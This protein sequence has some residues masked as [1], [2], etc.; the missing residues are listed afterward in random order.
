MCGIYLTNIPYQQQEIKAKIKKIGYRGPDNLGITQIE[1]LTLGHLRLSILDLDQRSNQ[2]F[3]FEQFY[4]TYNGEIYNFQSI[5]EDLIKLGYSFKTTSDTEVLVIGYSVWGKE[6]L[7]KL[8]GMF[9]FAIYDSKKEEIFCARDRLGVK[10][11]F[12]YWKDGNI[13]ICS[14]LSPLMNK[15]LTINQEAISI[16][17]DCG[18]IPS[19]FSIYNEIQ[20]LQPGYCMYI[21]LKE[22]KLYLEK[23]WDL[24]SAKVDESISYETAKDKLHELITDAVK[25][26]MQADVPL[27][28]FLSGGIDSALV[29]AIAAK[30]S[31]Q[32]L[33]TF[34][35][36]FEDPDFDESKVAEQYAGIINSEH[37]TTL[38][39]PKEVLEMLP[40]LINAYDE[41]FADSSA[42]PSLLLNKVTKQHVTVAL[43]GD[44]G[45]ESFIGYKHMLLVEQFKKL[46]VLHYHLRKV[47][48]WIPVNKL[49]NK[50]AEA[51]KGILGCKNENELIIKVFAQF[52]TLTKK[53][54]FKW[55]DK[56]YPQFK[57]LSKV[58]LQKIADLNIK[59]WLENDSNTKVDRA[60]MAF[61]VES[62]SPFLDYRI[63]EFARTLPMEYRYKNGVTKKILRDILKE[64]IPEEVFTQPKK[65]FAIPLNHWIKNELK[66][67]VYDKLNPLFLESIP[68]LDVKKFEKQMKQHFEGKRDYSFNIWK[69]YVLALWFEKY[70]V[71]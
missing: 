29:S 49:M 20:K 17:L 71:T 58:S 6:L 39:T 51:Y 40:H 36:A 27:G 62:R 32:K 22:K 4:I 59:L 46:T 12:Y 64:Y 2:P 47:L 34:T 45:D 50:Q 48:S 67:D 21:H 30:Y 14:Q 18:Y 15:N 38:C 41:P 7:S 31:S 55:V 9:A 60:S 3:Q 25:I 43:S 65:G 23:Y 13:E 44:G 63:V 10:P 68:N 53:R 35:I 16:Y 8:N 26:R 28:S 5:K 70:S 56:Y 66:D 52:D 11:F 54:N 33:K 19:P 37:T 24:Q 69:L 61:S 42:L 1:K 57:I